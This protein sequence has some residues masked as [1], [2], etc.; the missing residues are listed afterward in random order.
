MPG[1]NGR[2]NTLRGTAR[3]RGVQPS[4]KDKENAITRYVNRNKRTPERHKDT[5]VNKLRKQ[6]AKAE[7]ES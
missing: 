3:P 4:E 5:P 1:P 6:L 2:G 7:D